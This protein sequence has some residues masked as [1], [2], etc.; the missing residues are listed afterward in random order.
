MSTNRYIPKELRGL[1]EAEVAIKVLEGYCAE[2]YGE[3]YK[4]GDS[5]HYYWCSYY[6]WPQNEDPMGRYTPEYYKR[7][8]DE[9]IV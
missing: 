9:G 7:I 3:P 6:P 8:D 4:D 1:N 2:C 5:I